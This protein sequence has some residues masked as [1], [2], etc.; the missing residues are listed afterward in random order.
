[1]ARILVTGASGFVGA[2]LVRALIDRGDEV[3]AVV[4]SANTSWR[5]ADIL[6]RLSMHE[7]EMT[8]HDAITDVVARVMPEE[9]YHLAHYGGNRGESDGQRIRQVIIEGTAALYEACARLPN[10]PVIIHTGS[11]SEYGAKREAM[12]EDMVPEPNIEYGI[13]KL[14]AT[15]YGEYLRREKGMPI[16]TLRLFSPYGPYESAVRLFP[17][18]TIAFLKGAVPMLS[19][20]E[21]VRDFVYVDDVVEALLLA[22]HKPYG[23]YNVGTGVETTLRQAVEEIKREVGVSVPLVWGGDEGRGAIDLKKWCADTTLAKRELGWEAKTSLT[24]G[25]KKTVEWFRQND[26]LYDSLKG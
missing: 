19:H 13:A 20:P 5:L 9:V 12:R 16:T 3:H 10:V 15:L 26:S 25:I 7:V 4:H 2:N 1:M 14:W 18:V 11:S 17:A 6:K 24:E 21:T 22:T 8:N 23:I